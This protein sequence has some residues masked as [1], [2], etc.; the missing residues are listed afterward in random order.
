MTSAAARPLFLAVALLAAAGAGADGPP[1]VSDEAYRAT[2]DFYQYDTLVPLDARVV[3]R[4]DAPTYTRE[5]VV[6]TGSREDRVPAWLMLPK[7]GARP[8]PVVLI[9]DGWM[10][11]KDRWW[12]DDTWPQG[13]R[14]TKALAADGIAALVLDAQ[15]HGERAAHADFQAVESLVCN[16]CINL[17]R[18]MIVETVVD[19][20][21]ALDYLAT[22]EEIDR[23]R[24]GAIGFSMGGLMTFALSAVES[25]IKAAV[26]CVTPARVNERWT[27]RTAISPYTF[28][29]RV[30]IPALM[31]MGRTDAL[32]SQADA[33]ALLGALGSAEK[34]LEWYEAGHRLP[35]EYVARAVGWLKA[36]LK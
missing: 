24:V 21:R 26:P 20:R 16:E 6:F 8:F 1:A 30:T 13:G 3:K 9:L 36:H 29:P 32:Y 4:E 33:E 17:R 23:S 28:A 15:F 25:R 34:S 12:E 18:E 31:L 5:K 10:G 19:Y 11:T 27:S 14:L 22:R 35:P 2:V 7:A